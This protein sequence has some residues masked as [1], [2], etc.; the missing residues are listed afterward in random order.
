MAFNTSR[1]Y[2]RD[3]MIPSQNDILSAIYG[4]SNST[5]V[6]TNTIHGQRDALNKSTVVQACVITRCDAISNLR[7]WA[8]D[9]DGRKI[10][11]ATVKQDL[12]ELN[13]YNEY[14]DFRT[15]NNMLEAYACVYGR[16]YVYKSKLIGLNKFDYY[17]ISNHLIQPKYFQSSNKF[18][19]KEPDY[20]EIDLQT[21]AVLRLERDEIYSFTDNDFFNHDGVRGL[22]RLYSLKEP[23]S[24]LLSIGQM[25]TQLIADGGARGI[26]SQGARDVDMITAPFL[27]D[28]QEEIHRALKRYGGLRE[29]LKYIVMKGVANYVPLT[30]KIIDMQ[31]PELAKE[32]ALQIGKRFGI[33]NAYFALEPRFK[34]MPEARKEFHTGTIIPEATVRY[35]D[36]VK[37]KGIPAR[38]WEYYPDWSHLDFF[39][40]A[41]KESAI[42]LNQALAAITPAVTAGIVSKDE[43]RTFLEPYLE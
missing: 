12:K 28:E 38:D 2:T 6:N 41:L 10:K 8:K 4:N 24:T 42:A 1:I 32:A 31:L 23:I 7:I 43:A 17:P 19:E 40:E 27:D 11:N 15:F 29:Q 22:S 35:K 21:G 37:M 36:I 9:D 25:S 39:Q 16:G 3:G 20:Y 34:A 33:P 14:Q 30:S 13:Y 18:A 26:I 5:E